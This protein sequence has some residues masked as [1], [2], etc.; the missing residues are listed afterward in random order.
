MA[1]LPATT[2]RTYLHST[3]LLRLLA[4]MLLVLA[5]HFARLPWGETAAILAFVLL[6]VLT[7]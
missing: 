3:S 6:A 2:A 4:V 5:P 1:A 7:L